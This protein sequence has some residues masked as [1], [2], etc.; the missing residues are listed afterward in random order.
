LSTPAQHGCHFATLQRNTATSNDGAL[1]ILVVNIFTLTEGKL[2]R[3][4]TFP[5]DQYALDRFWS[6]Q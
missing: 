2:T 5:S 3:M 4:Q 1:D 6:A